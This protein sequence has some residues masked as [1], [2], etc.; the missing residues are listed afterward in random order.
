VASLPLHLMPLIVVAVVA[1]SRLSL[2]QAGWIASA[3]MLGQLCVVLSLPAL[4]YRSLARSAAFLAATVLTVAAA[5]TNG[6]T[7]LIMLLPWFFIGAG[8]GMLSFLAST[9]A[10]AADNR[11]Q[12]FG[13]RLGITLLLGGA[14][15]FLPKL[16]GNVINYSA[17]AWQITAAFLVLSALGLLLY[18]EPVY[19][20]AQRAKPIT[21]APS[22]LLG[23]GIAFLFFVGQ[24]GYWA[25][26]MHNAKQRGVAL[27]EV[28]NAIGLC[29]MIAGAFVLWVAVRATGPGQTNSLIKPAWVVVAG[30]GLMATAN[31]PW[32]FVAGV[33]AWELGVNTLSVRVQ[34]AVVQ[35]DP[36]TSGPWLTAA[37]CLGAATGPALHGFTAAQGSA[38]VFAVYACLSALI[39][40][41]WASRT[42]V[43]LK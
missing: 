5:A 19:A 8:G 17:L 18:R 37:I 21:A 38:W 3:Y 14:A 15:F 27:D 11:A 30:I 6:L 28:T 22:S 33:L 31:T 9:T 40:F 32:L 4:G 2:A 13:L 1:D 35:Q 43:M 10:A 34:T 24:P 12:A 26:A 16:F 39:P 25:Y 42:G 29:K 41:F 23:L 7:G 36:A 20:N